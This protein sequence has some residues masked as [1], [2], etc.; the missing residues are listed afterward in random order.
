MICLSVGWI[1]KET[2]D[3]ITIIPHIAGVNFKKS[4]RYGTG[5][6]TIP[7]VAIIKKTKLS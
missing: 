1:E 7:T 3:N 6:M 4:A 2:K 5:V